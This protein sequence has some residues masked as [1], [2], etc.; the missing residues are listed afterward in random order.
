MMNVLTGGPGAQDQLR[1]LFGSFPSGVAALA[2]GALDDPV[3][4]IVSTFQTGVSIDPPLVM[5]AITKTSTSWPALR[6]RERLGVSIL[7]D[8]HAGQ[9]RRLSQKSPDRFAGVALE[10]GQRGELYLDGAVTRM[11]CTVHGEHDAGDHTVVL[12]RVEEFS[13]Q[14]AEPLIFHRSGF[15]RLAEA[16]PAAAPGPAGAAAARTADSSAR[17]FPVAVTRS[18]RIGTSAP[19]HQRP[20]ELQVS[21]RG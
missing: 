17:M 8:D 18:E 10:R 11:S 9:V 7:S 16:Y 5:F 3:L 20:A 1:E 15:H 19:V 6:N 12:L 14:D 13:T 2:A 21:A 4:L